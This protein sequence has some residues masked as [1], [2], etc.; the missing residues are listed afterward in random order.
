VFICCS[1]NDWVPVELKTGFEIKLSKAKGGNLEEFIKNNK[2]KK[3]FSSNMQSNVLQYSSFLPPGKHF[4][5]YIYDRKF[6]FVS[7]NYDIVRYKG[8]NVFLN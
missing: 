2:N 5:Y 3:L 6:I 4:F 1:A 8:T 7:P